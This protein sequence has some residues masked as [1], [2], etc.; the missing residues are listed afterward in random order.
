MFVSFVSLPKICNC[1]YYHGVIIIWEKLNTKS[2]MRK[3]EVLVKS[4]ALYLNN[5]K[6][7]WCHMVIK[8]TKLHMICIWIQCALTHY[9]IMRCHTG[10]MCCVVF[11]FFQVFLSQFSNQISITQTNKLQYFSVYIKCYLM[12][13]LWPTSTQKQTIFCSYRPQPASSAKI[14]TSKELLIMERS[15]S[16]FHTIFYIP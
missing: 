6:I 14:Y 9:H 15:T 4:S 11:Q 3:I 7:L 12:Y 1:I 13:S 5:M 8:F 10:T 2:T 16:D